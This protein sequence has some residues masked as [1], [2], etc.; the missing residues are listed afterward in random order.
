M[1]ELRGLWSTVSSLHFFS[2]IST[3][4][5]IKLCT[6]DLIF[7]I[8]SFTFAYGK[9]VKKLANEHKL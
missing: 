6:F 9:L 4:R 2:C 3:T 8:N 1:D 7:K 5:D